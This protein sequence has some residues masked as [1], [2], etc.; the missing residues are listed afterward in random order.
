H[1]GRVEPDEERLVGLVL[2]VDEV[3]G[4]REK[5]LVDGLHAL[6]VERAG[7]LDLAIREGMDDAP[8]PVFLPEFWILRIE[9][10]FRL[11]FGVQVV[12]IAEE[13]VEAVIGRQML[14]LVAEMVLA[15]LAGGVA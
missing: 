9:I 1:A 5:L 7:I 15:E 8:G 11:L 14:V 4:G 3:L 10:A 12:E 2:A 6:G 13:L